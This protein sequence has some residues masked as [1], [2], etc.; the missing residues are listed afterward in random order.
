MGKQRTED[1]TETDKAT[2]NQLRK[3]DGSSS[4]PTGR[5]NK[6]QETLFIWLWRYRW[7][8]AAG[9]VALIL[10]NG[11]SLIV[12]LVIREAIDL[13]ARG[14]RGYIRSALQIAGLALATLGL[15]FLWR[16]FLIGTSRRIEQA[17][18]SKFYSHLLRMD[19]SFYNRTKTGDLM[20]HA[21]NDIDAVTR[22]CG[23]GILTLID[24]IILIPFALIIMSSIAPRLTLYAIL[25]LPF[26]F[27]LMFGFGKVIHRRFQ[28]VQQAFSH[29]MEN[30]RE[31]VAGIRVIKAFAQEEGVNRDFNVINTELVDKNMHL[32]KIWGLF[33]PLISLLGGMSL[34]IVLWVGG[35]NVVGG[36]LSLGDFV[37]IGQY[38]MIISWPMVALGWAVNLIQRGRASLQRINAILS[39]EPVIST[40]RHPKLFSSSIIEF[41]NLS[42]GYNNGKPADNSSN[43]QWERSRRNQ[44]GREIV[45]QNIDLMIE[46]GMTLGIIGHTGAGKSTL[47]RLIPRIWDP[48]PRT[49]F[50]GG[51]DVHE[52]SLKE[53]RRQISVVPQDSFLFSTTLKEN[54]RF[55]RPEATMDEIE[56]A[57]QLAEIYDEI[58]EFPQGFN[59]MVGERGISLSGGQKQRLAIARAIILNPRILIIDDSLSAV[60]AEKEEAI[61]DNLQAIF[62]AKTCIVIAHRVSA[63]AN[64][65]KIIVID[66]GRIV[67]SG[68]HNTLVQAEGIYSNLYRLQQIEKGI[69]NGL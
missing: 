33:Q 47:I 11:V 3:N 37:A 42:F 65:D 41:R 21:T 6:Q 48:P 7:R 27:L 59:T 20:A 36:D 38:V 49:L 44:T 16:Y 13:F 30:V 66:Q 53:L 8:V 12:P 58:R 17:L 24:P 57:A 2:A 56:R 39:T 1:I 25:P 45:L 10:L 4:I 50:I 51:T 31:N 46:E 18:R 35:R 52:L 43:G 26:L 55:G 67:E 32:V 61:L 68:K 19:A 22:A 69:V 62:T 23:F 15:R 28:A 64:S 29:V 60:D 54:I 63:V 9:L 34:A 40:P 14:E 5:T